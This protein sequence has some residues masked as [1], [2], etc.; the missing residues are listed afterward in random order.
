MSTWWHHYMTWWYWHDV[1]DMMSPT[2]YHVM[3]PSLYDM[4]I[5]TW[6]YVMMSSCWHWHDVMTSCPWHHVNIIMSCDDLIRL[7][8]HDDIDMMSCI[9]AMSSCHVNLMT[10]WHD[11]ISCHHD[12]TWCWD[13]IIEIMSIH[14]D[15]VIMSRHVN[16]IMLIS[17]SHIMMTWCQDIMPEY[18]DVISSCQ[19]MMSSYHDMTSWHDIMTCHVMI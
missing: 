11:M 9:H 16:D 3:M 7:T 14:Y 8:W 15:N 5:L 19:D 12:I 10:S 2:L 4:I 17:T 18:H 13:D 1:I 6:C